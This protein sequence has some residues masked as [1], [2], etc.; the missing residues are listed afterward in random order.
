MNGTFATNATMSPA[1]QSALQM[2][3]L[4]IPVFPLW[5]AIDGKCACGEASCPHPAKHPHRTA[6]FKEA[7]T[8]P[9]VINIWFRAPNLNVGVRT[10]VEILDSGKM[11]VVADMDDYKE[12]GT[13]DFDALI[14]ENSVLPETAEVLTGGGGRHLYF[15][16]DKKLAFAGKLGRNIEFKVNG[17]VVGP[18]SLHVSGKRYEWEASSDLFDNQEIAD[19]PQ[20]IVDKFAKGLRDDRFAVAVGTNTLSDKDL[21]EI[22][23]ALVYIKADDYYDW[24]RVLMALKSTGD[25]VQGFAIADQW[26]RRSPKYTVE[27]MRQKWQQIKPE[28]GITLGT[29]IDMGRKAYADEAKK[30]DLSFLL[31][32]LD[33]VI[34]WLPPEP[35]T[36]EVENIPYP[37][38]ALPA[39]V[40]DAA[41]EVQ[42]F[43]QAPMAMVACSAMASVSA[44]CQARNDVERAR[45]LDG[46]S[47]LY[48]LSVADSGERKSTLDGHFSKPIRDYE[49]RQAKEAEA[50][51]KE[52][53]ADLAHWTSVKKG[54]EQAATKGAEHSDKGKSSEKD[55][56]QRLREHEQQKPAAP[57]IPRLIYRDATPEAL[58]HCIA[59]EWPSA[60]L[61]S[62]EGGIV[63]G[64]HGMSKESMMRNL[65][66][67]NE[68]WDGKTIRTDRR[69]ADSS[70][71]AHGRLTVAIQVQH[72]VLNAFLDASAQQARGSGFL[73][74]FLVAAPEST[75]GKRM[76]TEA[77]EH[78]PMLERYR[79]RI[80]ELLNLPQYIE[81][82]RVNP[83]LLHLTQEAKRVWIT[84]H[85]EIEVQL[86]DDGELRDVRDV[87]SKIADN[88]A[89]LAALF[90]VVAGATG[91]ID[92]NTMRNACRIARWHLNESRRLLN[93]PATPA[94]S[95]AKRLNDWL[96]TKFKQQDIVK[97]S[98]TDI[99]H[100][101]PAGMRKKE[102]LNPVLD[103]LVEL[104][105][106][107]MT[108]GA[109]RMVHVNPA[110]LK[111]GPPNK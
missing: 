26:S 80:T 17:Y 78:W 31:K 12:S 87:A 54:L 14:A 109:P 105:R 66:T 44:A 13:D 23:C 15:W 2:A 76:F 33:G 50:N 102:D 93:T 106:V 48:F 89:R 35:L 25:E 57:V 21:I 91:D 10:G 96:V 63:F 42:Q 39:I 3:S 84:F 60:A 28:G 72:S 104:G 55:L 18:G 77:P 82:C 11:L 81:D 108:V 51:M 9:T 6:S 94:A 40:A 98:F 65:A 101:G 62:S 59:K 99:Q 110:L 32:S 111:E 36:L 92:D 1:H 69:A 43:V 7:T 30:V 41:I 4:G 53:T 95:K 79:A 64:G 107:K 37:I 19:L 52:Y 61:M 100:N 45:G 58:L 67:I 85:D 70:Y 68:L 38:D 20:W 27:G 83:A 103:I 86:D 97:M 16:A 34:A 49:Q 5:G 88:A 73:A 47:S 74:R 75:Q 8:D 56:R 29:L 22:R 46:P 71:S 90:H 24:M